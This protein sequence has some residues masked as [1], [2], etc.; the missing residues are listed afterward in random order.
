MF[1][2]I[3]S[4]L[5]PFLLT[6]NILFSQV[7][8]AGWETHTSMKDVRSV[9]IAGN[10]VWAAST[11]GLFT[12]NISSP[13]STIKKYTT[14][15]GL[16]SNELT[17]STIDNS[18]NIWCGATDGSVSVFYP[19]QN[20][21]RVITDIRNSTEPS[22][23]INNLFQ[24]GNY[25]FISTQF[26]LIKFDINLFQFVDQPYIYLGSLPVKTPVIYTTVINDTIWAGTVNGIAYANIN[27]NLP[28]ASS[29]S[30]FTTANSVMRANRVNTVTYFNNKIFFG[31]DHGMVYFAN[32]TLNTYAP[33]YNGNV[34]LNP[35]IS[36]NANSSSLY[37]ST[38]RDTNNIY[39]AE[40]NN[41][42]N[43]LLIIPGLPV[44]TLKVNSNGDL[45]LGTQ[46]KGVDIF[47]NNS[48]TSIIPNGPFSNL[49]FNVSVDG[50]KN[51]W[52]VS[53]AIGNWVNVSGIYK[54]NG[55]NWKNY[56]YDNYPVLCNCGA[57][58]NSIYGS[59]FDPNTV[60]VGGFG[61]GLL[62]ITGDSLTRF[63]DTNSILRN[64]IGAGFVLALSPY[65]DNNGDLWVLNNYTDFPFVNFTRQMAYAIPTGNSRAYFFDNM[66]IDNYNT[67]W[68]ILNNTEPLTPRGLVY[69]NESV[70]SYGLI[71]P[72]NLGQDVTSV[73]GIIADRDGQIWVATNNGIII[74]ADSYQVIANPNSDP[75]RF[76]MR[77]IENGLSTPLL[78]SVT[79]LKSDALNNKWIATYGTGVIY[80]SP[81][82]STILKKYTTVNSPIA[83]NKVVSIGTDQNTGKVYFG[84]NKGLSINSSIAVAPLT[85]CVKITAGPNPFI[86]PNDALLRI[87]GLV[88]ESTVKILTI[89]G[90]LVYEFDS[91]GGKIAN[92]DGRDVN[93]NYV[94]SGIYIIA[95]YNKDASKVCT[96]KVAIVRK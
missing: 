49:F 43:A 9:N 79:A 40:A 58:W 42:N 53:G 1:K 88:A 2:A 70:P 64:Y 23:Q 90:K 68:A 17:C 50:N 80:V 95:G 56:T 44:N 8:A 96:G 29:W 72:A 51:L 75:T 35:I 33:L 12:F 92:W 13:S 59:R 30:N 60:W 36:M 46:Y 83:D 37:F 52:A 69:F 62:K 38:Y 55:S 18:G 15:D 91:P 21:W 41:I 94:S 87:D 86:I 22:K 28:I 7:T 6:S 71:S 78:E 74:I 34:V 73:T 84:T 26:C 20:K 48:H 5:I 10:I 4:L 89:S 32:H 31:T 76:K 93:G 16:L 45:Y 81:D 61:N 24:Y 54:Y 11:G 57:G 47:A 85:D 82:G 19:S 39:K 14:F 67:K 65:E 27:S 66:V 63:T 77:I 25:M 3:I